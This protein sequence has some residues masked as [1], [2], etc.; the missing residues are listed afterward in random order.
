[1]HTHAHTAL[2][3]SGAHTLY[4]ST[5]WCAHTSTSGQIGTTREEN[6]GKFGAR[7]CRRGTPMAVWGR[8]RPPPPPPPPLARSRQPQT[9]RSAAAGEATAMARDGVATVRDGEAT[10]RDGT[11]AIAHADA[12]TARAD[13][14]TA[15]ADA[16]AMARAVAVTVPHDDA[17]TQHGGAAKP[18]HAGPGPAPRHGKRHHH[19]HSWHRC[20]PRDR[21]TT[22]QVQ[23]GRATCYR[24]RHAPLH[25]LSAQ[26][27]RRQRAR[28]RCQAQ[29]QP[30]ANRRK[31]R[32]RR[33]GR[34]PA[35]AQRRRLMER[36]R[37]RNPNQEQRR[38]SQTRAW[39]LLLQALLHHQRHQPQTRAP[40]RPLLAC[41]RP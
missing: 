28:R 39:R 6:G 38:P 35:G 9:R 33:R 34:R 22:A 4:K 41:S 10:A 25:V 21:A 2:T 36:R 18:L 17:A 12:A 27:G 23:H 40:Q 7:G 14:A 8:A 30:D 29:T 5:P 19:H 11:G 13:A 16:A 37:R 32:R 1:M 24:S 26:A 15:R 3:R 20:R 31:E